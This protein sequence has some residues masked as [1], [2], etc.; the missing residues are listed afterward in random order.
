[1]LCAWKNLINPTTCCCCALLQIPLA[2]QYGADI[3]A[4]DFVAYNLIP[5]TIGNWI[6]SELAVVAPLPALFP[7]FCFLRNVNPENE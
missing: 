6:V 3:N 2:I 1:M 5:S 4:R 7:F